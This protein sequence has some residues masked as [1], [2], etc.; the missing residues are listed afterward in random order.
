MSS[1]YRQRQKSVWRNISKS[2]KSIYWANEAI[3]LP[4]DGDDVVQWWGSTE[5]LDQLANRS[6][7]VILSN[8]DLTYLDMGFGRRQ[9]LSY[10][11]MVR[12]R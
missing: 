9:G 10:G 7:E 1:Y 6:N 8:Q 4:L 2:K 11:T 12:W 5:H 3:D